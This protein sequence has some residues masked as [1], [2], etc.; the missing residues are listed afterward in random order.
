MPIIITYI[1]E[2]IE[3][4][5]SHLNDTISKIFFLNI[6]IKKTIFIQV[7]LT[8]SIIVSASIAK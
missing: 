3:N 2:E 1:D 6:I 8:M 4:N 7:T 5:S